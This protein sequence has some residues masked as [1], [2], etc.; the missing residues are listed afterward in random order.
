MPIVSTETMKQVKTKYFLLDTLKFLCSGHYEVFKKEAPEHLFVFEV[1]TDH[2]TE[3]G[4]AM[5][6]VAC[7]GNK[8]AMITPGYT[9]EKQ[10]VIYEYLLRKAEPND[11]FFV[12]YTRDLEAVKKCIYSEGH[13]ITFFNHD[14]HYYEP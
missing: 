5:V 13:K 1:E 4:P 6:A 14:K 3:D 2:K 8:C 10:M 9:T 11:E 12:F 7:S